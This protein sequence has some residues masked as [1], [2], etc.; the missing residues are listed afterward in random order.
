MPTILH[1]AE[2]NFQPNSG[3]IDG[4][5]LLTDQ[6][7]YQQGINPKYLS[8]DLRL[9]NPGERSSAYHF[10]RYADELF[11]IIRGTATLRTPQGEQQVTAGDTCYFEAGETG[12]HQ[13]INQSDEPCEYLDLRTDIGYDVVEYPDSDKLIICPT[14]ETFRRTDQRDYWDGEPKHTN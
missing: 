5:R 2:R 14:A 10:H 7:R 11:Y 12:A 13:L 1:S 4:Y 3:R 9:L 8:F 6:T